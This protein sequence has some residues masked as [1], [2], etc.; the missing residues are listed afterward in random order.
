MTDVTIGALP[1]GGAVQDADALPIDRGGATRRV[2]A[3][4]LRAGLAP[5]DHGHTRLDTATSFVEPASG[6]LVAAD[7][8][9]AVVHLVSAYGGA[10]TYQLP[11]ASTCPGR[12]V[13][14]KK[15]DPSANAVT[16]TEAGAAGPDNEAIVLAAFGHGI[17]V[18]SNGARWHILSV[19]GVPRDH[20]QPWSSITGRP[21]T[22]TGYGI[23]SIDGVPVGAGDAAPGAFTTLAVGGVPVAA[24]PMLTG[25]YGDD[26]EAAAGG[27]V[28]GQA[29][30][31][32][33]TALLKVRLA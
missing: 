25:P 13:A 12:V 9:G 19:N 22:A 23:A 33:T 20:Q 27:V 15:T 7:V 31:E 29:Y 1:D 18:A 11:A 28:I 24:G 4:A 17:I 32:A 30:I 14:V 8:A 26:A 5:T 3:A 6:G 10:V 16:V 2:S 21:D